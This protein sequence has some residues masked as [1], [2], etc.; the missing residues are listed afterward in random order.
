LCFGTDWCVGR[1]GLRVTG[2][3][4]FAG[5]EGFGA[6]LVVVVGGA[7]VVVGDAVVVGAT[8]GSGNEVDA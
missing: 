5:F 1:D 2:R 3:A 7:A 8:A 6:G 4:C